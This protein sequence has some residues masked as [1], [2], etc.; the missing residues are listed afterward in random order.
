MSAPESPVY[1]L[2]R[3]SA[4]GKDAVLILVNTD[5]EKENFITLAADN[6]KF[7]ISDFKFELLGQMLPPAV[8]A[9][10][11]ANFT[12]VPGAVYCLATTEK[13]A[14]L[15]GDD[16]RRARAQAAFAFESLNKIVPAEAVDG[17]DWHWL[18]EQVNGSPQ[19]LLAAASEFADSK[20]K[21]SLA[22]LLQAA[23]TGKIFPRVVRWSLPDAR[24]VTLVPPGH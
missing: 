2:L 5:A 23:A 3:D 13:P 11:Q 22:D 17:L 8:F 14:G 10:E 9:K 24:R 20:T 1:A 4:E 15:N 16:Y 12:L 7:Q 18:A 21:T 6:F 19:N